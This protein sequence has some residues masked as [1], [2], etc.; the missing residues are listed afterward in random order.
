MSKWTNRGHRSPK[1]A[2][3][4]NFN[5]I[6]QVGY[7]TK[8]LDPY[9]PLCM[10]PD[11]IWNRFCMN[12]TIILAITIFRIIGHQ[13]G[14]FKR[15]LVK[16]QILVRPSIRPNFE[17]IGSVDLEK[18]DMAAFSNKRPLGRKHGHIDFFASDRCI[19]S[20]TI[21]PPIIVQF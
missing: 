5:C 9:Q 13:G 21:I 2:M 17:V 16:C 10:E 7:P 15:Y 3:G 18:I 8:Y 20:N 12:T 6:V 11:P 1:A 14:H 4:Q 19:F